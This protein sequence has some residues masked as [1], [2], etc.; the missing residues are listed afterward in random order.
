MAR[1]NLLPWREELRKQL[2]KQFIMTAAGAAVVA[3]LVVLYVHLH[4][5]GMIETQN[6]RN[7]FL[8]Q[9]IAEV[10]QR[11]KEIESLESQK[12]QLLA[13]MRV[14]EQLQRHRPEVVHLVE[15]LAKATPDGLWMTSVKQSHRNLTIQGKAQS[16]AR[17]S[18]LMRN[19]DASDW[20]ENPALDIIES[21]AGKDSDR[22]T[23]NF[24]LRVMQAGSKEGE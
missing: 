2:R 20:F 8:K 21:A 23:R 14:I 16:N 24:T 15:E 5:N 4:I 10:E 12:E 6:S 17:V 11:I 13:R 22:T 19:L 1:I 3:A 9:Q 18:S 7:N